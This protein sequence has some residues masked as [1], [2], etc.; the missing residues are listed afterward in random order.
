M[1]FLHLRLLVTLLL[2]ILGIILYVIP[3]FTTSCYPFIIYFG[4]YIV[5][6]SSIYDF[7]LPFYY[8][9]WALYCMSF[10]QLRLLVTLLLSILGIILYVIPPFTTSC[11][12]FIIYFGH[13][14]VCHSS[15][16]DFLLPFY[17][18]FWALYCMSFLH[19]RLLATLLL[20]I[21]GIVLYVIPPIT[22]SCYPFI[23][24]F[25]HYIVCHSSIY[26]FLLP[27]YY[28]FWALYC[29]SFLHL[30]LLATLLLSILGIILYVIPPFTTSCY[31]FII[32]FGHCIVCHSSN[33]D[34]LLPFYYLFW[35]LYC[36]SFLHL[37]LL[38]TLLL[39]ILGIILYVIPPITTSCYPFIIYFGHYIVCH[40][41]NYDFLLPFY[42]LFWALYCMSFL[43]LR[44]LVTLLLSMLGIILYV[45]PPITISCYP[46]IIYFGHC[47]VCH[48]SIYDFLLPFYY[49]F[50]ALYCM[51]FLHL[52]LLV[53]LL[54]SILGIV[55]YVIP[56]ITTSCYPFIIY[57]G[58]YIVCHSSIYDFLLPFYYLCWALYCMS[59]LQLRFLVTLLL[60]ILGIVLYVIPPFTTSC[61]PFIIY[62]GHYIVCHSSIYD[63]LLPFYYLCW[64]LYC[65]SFLQLRF[66]VTLLL[67]I[68]GIVLYVIPPFTT[69]CYPFIIYVGHYIVCHSSIYDFLLPFY[70]L[71]WALYCMSFLQLRLLV[72]L[73]LSILGI[74]LYV[75]PPITTSCYPFIIYFGHYIVC[76]SS[77]YDFL[78]PFYYLCWAL[79]CMSFLQL[80]LFVTLLLSMLGIILYVIPPFTTS[81]YPFIIYVGHY[82]VC[83]SSIYDFLLPFYYLFWALYCMSFLHLRLLA[84]LLLSMLGIILY[85]IP[86]FT[87]SCYPFIIYFGHYIVCHSSIYGFLL[88]FYYLCWALYC[89]S[90]LHLRLLATL[91][92]SI[93]GI[94]LYVIPPITTSCYPFI[95]YF[96]HCIVCHSSNYDFLLPFYYLFWALYCMSFL[97]LRLLATLLLSMFGII[98]YVIPPITTSCYPFIIYVGHY[99]V[100]HSSIYDFLLPFYYLCWAL[101]CMSFLHLRLLVT[102]LLS[103]LGIILYVIPPFTTSC[104][105]FIIY[106]GHY[107]VCHSSIYGF[108]LPFYYLCWA[109]YCM[110][111]L[112]LRLLVT[113]L[114][115][116]L[117]IIL[118]VIPP[119]TASCYPFIIYVG[120]YIVCHSSI[121]DFLLPFYYLFWALYCMSFL[122]LRLLVTLLLSILGIVLYVIPPITTSCYPFIIYF[123][124]CIVCHS[125]NYDFLLPFYYLFWALY[126]MSFLH[127]RLLVTLLLSILGIVLYVIPPFTTSCYPFIIY[128]GHCIVC[129]SSN[130]DFLLPFYY[131]F[132]ALYCMS[133]LQLRL[134]VTLLLSMLGIVLYVI[135]PITTSCYPFIIYF[136]HCIVCHSS[137]Y[138]F[139]LPFY[140]L[141]WALYCMSFLQL[142]LLVTLL[143]SMLGII[144]YVIPPFTTSCYPF[145][146]YFGHYI[147]C[148]SSIY[149]FLLPF[150]YLCWALYCMSFLHLRLLVTLL[151][152]IL[153]IILY[154]IPPFTTSC[155][156]FII[157]FGHCIV[158]H[159]SIY[160]FLLPFYYLFWAL[161][162]MS[163]LQLRLLA[164]LLLSILGIVLYVIPPITTSC[165]PFIIYF[166]H[167]IVCHSSI[168]DFLLPFYYLFW[169]LYCMS[170]LHLRLLATLLLSI[171]G[172]VLYVIPPITTSCYPFIIYFG[173]C[174]VCHSS[175]YD[176]LLPFYYLCWALYCM[177]FLQLRLLATLL[178][179]IL[180]IVLYVIPPITT[181][182]YPFI[183]YFG[184]CIVCH[185]S[186]YDF[187]LPFYYLCWALYC[188]SF[189]QLRLLA[190]LL[191]SMLGIVLYVIPPITTSCYPFIIYFGH[192]IVCHSSNYDF[193]LP[194]YYLFWALYCMSFLQ[195]RLLA[196]LLLSILGIVL[197]VIT[198]ITISCYPFIIY[199]GHCIVCH[200]S[201]YDFL[202]SFYYLFWAL[203][204]MSFLHLRFLV[205]LLLS[206]LGIVLYVIPP[207][208]TSCYPFI[209]YFGHC[210]VCHS[211]NYDFLLP[212]YYLFWAL[213][214]MSF[215][216]LRLLV[217][218][219][220]SILGIV[221]Y[222]IP[223]FTT[224]CYPFIIYFG[225]YI[226]CHSSIYGFLLPFYYLCWALYC[227]SFLHLRL[228][229]TLLLS[230]LGI[231]LYVIPPFT[232]SCYP[233]IIYVGHYI[234]CHSSIY[235]FLLPFY[236]LFWALYCMSFLHL[237]LLVTLLLSI[238]GIVLYVIP[239]ITTSC[240]PFIIYF[241]DCIVCHSSNYD[242]LLPFYYLFWALYCM[243]FLHLRLLV[244]LLLSILGIVLYVIP[245]FTT[246]CYPFI[247]YFG[248]CIVCHSSN[249]DILLPFY[250]LFWALYCMSFLQLRLLV[251]LLLSMLGIVLYVI[252]PIT[253]SCYPFII[254][255]GHCIVCHSSNYDFLLPFYYLFWALYCMSFLQ[256]RLLVTLLL[257]MLGIILYVIPPFTT[258]CY[259][260]IIY[261]G[262]YIVCHSSI[263]GF[264]L[265]FYYLC[266]ALY[267]MSFLHLRL[268][269]TLLLSILGIILY[270]IPPFTAS[271]YPF[272]IYVGHYIVCHSSIYDFL[273]PFYYL[274][275]ALYCMSFLH[276]RLLVTLLLSILGIVLYVIPP[277]TT[278][279]YPFII[280]FGHC[281]VCHSSNYD[282]LLP[283]YYL[284]WALYCM[285]FL[286]LRLL[287]TLL[288][289]ILGIVLYVIPPFTTSCYPFII[290]FG[291]CIVCHS[292]N[293][294]FLL[295]FYYLFWALYCMSFLQLR[296]LVTLLLSMLGIVLYVIPPITTS[297]YPFIIYFGHC[298]VCHSSNYDFLLPIYYLFWALYCMS[299]LQLR[300]LV[301][302]LLSM[303]GIVLY[304]IPP[305]TTSCYPFIIYVGHCIVCHSSNYDFLLPFYYLFWA[306]YCMSFLQLRLLAT[307]LLS[308]L[309]IVLYVIPPIT[310]SCYPFIIYFGHCIVCHYS[311]YDFL[312]PF[313]YLFWALYCMSFLQLRLLAILLLSI[314]GIV[315]YVIPPFTISCYP[316]II[317]F[318]HCI[319]CHSSIYDFLLPFYYLFWA[320]YCMSFLQLRLLAT[321]LLS[322]LGIV[323]Y[324][325]PPITTSCYPFIIYFGHCIVCHS[326]NYDFLLPFYY[327]FWALYCMSFLQLR[328]LAILLLSIL[329]I[330][331]YV[332]PP[333]TISCYPFII[334]FGHCIAC[335]SSNY[336]FLLPFYYLFWA[337]YCMS[338]LQ[339]RLLV[340]LLLSILGIVLY[341]IPP[342]TTS[343]Y[344]FIIYFGHCI[345]CHSSNYDFL[346]P[347]YYLFW[348]LY[349]MSFLHLRLLVTLLLS[350][351]G[352][353]LYVIPPITTSCYPFIIYF[354]HCIVCHSSNYDFLLPFYYLFWALYCMSF[355]HLRLLVTLLLSILGIV[356]YVIPP[357]TTSCY[358]FIIYFGHCIVCHS[359]NYDFLLPFYYLFW[360]LYC[361]SFL[362]LRLLATLLLSILGIVLYVIPPFTTS[363]YPFIIYFGHCIVCH[364][365]NY[366]FLLPFYYLFWALYCMSFLHLRLLVTLLLSILGIVLYVIPPF[367]ASCYP[368]IIYFGHCIVCH[369]SNYDF[370]LPFYY[371]F[372]ALYCMSFLQLR[373]L[374]TLLLSI[375]GIVLYVIPP[376]TT[377]CYPFI[378]YFGH[379][380]VCHSSNYDFLLPFYYLFWALYCMSFLHLRLLATLLLS[381][382]GIVLYVIPPI[383]ASCYPFIIYFGHCI[384]C[385]SSNYD[386]LLPFYYLFW[387]LYCM[388]FL[389]LRLLVTLLLSI[390][391][392]VLYVI[393]PFTTSCYPFIIYFGHCIVCHFS[394]YDFLLPFYYL[395]WALYCMSFL[396]LRLLATLLLSILGIVLYVIPP[397]TAS[398]YPFII[399]FG[400]CIVCHSSIYDFLLLFYYLFWAL[401]CM[402]FLQLRLLVTLLLSILG[403]VLYVIPPITASCYPFIIYF[404]HCIVC[405][406][407]IYDFLLPFYYLFWALYCMSFLQL[408]FLATLLLSILGIVLYVIPPFTASCYP[409]IIYFGHCIVCHS[410]NYGFLL[411]FYYLFWALYCMSFLHLRLLVTLLLSILGIVLYVIP[412]FTTSCYPFIIYFGHCIV[413]H[414]SIYGFL[415][416]F[417]Y[418]FWA[419]Y[420]MSFLQLRFLATLLLS[421]LGIVLYVIPPI[422]A[423]CYPFIIYFG[424]C[425]VCH[426]SNY[427]F[428]LPFY[429][430]FWALYCMSFLHLRLLVTLLL[431]IL[432]I[433]L[434][435][436]PPFTT[437]CYPFII[438]FGHCIVCHSSIYDFLLPFYYLFW[439]LYCMSFLHLRL[440]ATLLLSILGI[441]LYVIPPF[442]TSC[443]PFI[444][445][446]GHCIVCHSSNYDFLLPF[447]Y[448]FWA[449]YCMSF[450][451]LR[452]LATLLLSILGIVLYVIPPIT[453]SCYPFNIY[454]GHCI[455]CHSSNY[456]FLLPFYY[457][458][459][460][461]YCISFLQLRLLAT[462][463]LS[464][465]GIILYVIPPFTTSCYPFIIYFGHCIVCHSSNYDFLLPFYYLFWALYC[466]SFLQL[467]LLATLLLSILGIVLYVIPPFTTSHYPFVIFK[468]F[469]LGTVSWLDKDTA[470]K[471]G[472]TILI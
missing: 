95:I 386:F 450:L 371:L 237:R 221:L 378:I 346:L 43:H 162:C 15:I 293:Y 59:F 381:I 449:L 406:S 163:F 318:G 384:V 42:Y 165:Y 239:P 349:C 341:V 62:F 34:F 37:R 174:I 264:L 269:V 351:L 251:T 68:L 106:F 29:M 423:S 442:T 294:D 274:F 39:S 401:Y 252:P 137:N 109:L 50:W 464:I 461:L 441:V 16:Y 419:L 122:H 271:C 175:N 312:L 388:S 226:V 156:P 245:P 316:F 440:L 5:C 284:F 389:Q 403:I 136:G 470:I 13:Y 142:R 410:S 322:I 328:L 103:M 215:L 334:Y 143:L 88:P 231:I 77:N 396:Q 84:T 194:F 382:L 305:I 336:D 376:F 313:Y 205:T 282:F 364:S 331:L 425:I 428:L 99:I 36:M 278:S 416:P 145:I 98:L 337:L 413:C 412:P 208:T 183:I 169:A 375:L 135:P 267:C 429:Y 434:Y 250:Y 290:Y 85:V 40:S 94:V 123:G 128:F 124:H 146:I 430:L 411:P 20:S 89:M 182:C 298:I 203:Y 149:G 30:R 472:E 393:P 300:L 138:D 125:S 246:S 263:Y 249:Y 78:L 200:S 83:H 306:L 192:C 66:L 327:L 438:Y 317:Y 126:C 185:S 385:H 307:L 417:Y 355:L 180:G 154:V 265:P 445:Y 397:F 243:S 402:S 190:T 6:H 3:P 199:F 329:G 101:Y 350:I 213:Y 69:S 82:I 148:H 248:H 414:S 120:H 368:F 14:I 392:I 315:L 222:V 471:S 91:L 257:S 31:P 130:Y 395:F 253:T 4:H 113:L 127:L 191:L 383:T 390:L 211:S 268:L 19:L 87:T 23:I 354:G 291:H 340:T 258:S 391:G 366:D 352:I 61:Y 28:L 343:C 230:I 277:I 241:G 324:V 236:Y 261:F 468:V 168:Y 437:S 177:S 374:A 319:V 452:L 72:T 179:S 45:I 279:C 345:V 214:C 158:C 435:V 93:L 51:S 372:W 418:L 11:Y 234:V 121:Y 256:L 111:F 455:V 160:D 151:L 195:L 238:L 335:H 2:S 281:I 64:A 18:L 74:V 283:F 259:P 217:T 398:C 150:Y 112:H 67:S 467:R 229:V 299:F 275:W 80:R 22:T 102:L 133:F 387:A 21:L 155:Y 173:H 321:L 399:Y 451:Q 439:A 325:I 415:L 228:L 358:P 240:Y 326:S 370:L 141:F 116:I 35:A 8:L 466:M 357:I 110:S 292:S 184:H 38:V 338:F 172:I 164:T 53:T 310:T 379:C 432:G 55:L 362:Q 86:P 262:H 139:L 304:V 344:P 105:P 54:L 52:R 348:A 424:H 301:T 457:L 431:S 186:N 394:N 448:L 233:F 380:I 456:D 224:S 459:W 115:S 132:W 333:F 276:L 159:S 280:Y 57:F 422:T 404:G 9:F 342:I 32:Y 320:L 311:N 58:H 27:F 353:V 225:H 216:Q 25:G 197:Y 104:Y 65:M 254:Y 339:L 212:F 369:S 363:C 188:M 204:C 360:A 209:I 227:M 17:Y 100:C 373:L 232:A 71:C 129:H 41:S 114:L 359:S 161:Y 144:L 181:S 10:L 286:H 420:C 140:Y 247:I 219:L 166:G 287:V 206:I 46:F 171:L 117:G 453:T 260:F 70:Y 463:L 178:L 273:L 270:V 289:S 79:Y 255:F 235:D 167:C 332:I 201:N 266:W 469:F 361:M 218:L 285:S 56:P 407:S 210:I 427:G 134:L 189:L 107:I 193:L 198:P 400:H 1:S 408:R 131:L 367:T 297:C 49:L 288:L 48:S 303:L 118:Y 97:Q 244:T 309:G 33:Y 153:G 460:A 377:S 92:L 96:G 347:F 405:H 433:V 308:I 119:F 47:I 152:S 443:Y 176:F 409:F 296:L 157:Y 272:I 202:L 454:F 75:I 314:L 323:L 242:F 63:F 446:F 302:L 73:L 12:P 462:L 187:L 44:L 196:T 220:L 26:D 81:C 436:I 7:L 223:P 356:L 108:L 330:V 426:S 365:S 465:L 60:S 458:F 295:P 76:H 170:F 207:F 147:V 24:Y 444:I 447:Y 421:I 90:F